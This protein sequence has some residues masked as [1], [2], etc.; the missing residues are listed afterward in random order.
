[1]SEKIPQNT[2]RADILDTGHWHLAVDISKDGLGAWLLPNA[3]LSINPRIII[4]KKWSPSEEGL[5]ERIEDA[6]YEN[7]AVLDDYSA[8]IIVESDRQLWLPASSYPTDDDCAEAY[9]KIYGGDNLDV[10]VN[11]LGDEK[12]AFMLVPGLKSFMQRSFPGAR[13]WSQQLLLR[14]AGQQPHDSYKYLVDIRPYSVDI[15][16]LDRNKLL[17]STTHIW[18]NHSDIA[19]IIFNILK[20]FKAQAS[21]TEIVF[22]GI[23]AVRQSIGKALVPYFKSVSQKNHELDG[24]EIPTGVYLAIN[25][26]KKYA[27]HT[28]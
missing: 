9:V 25:R 13:I 7:P 10:M 22:S 14:E 19:Y 4:N 20:T 18:K 17:C 8:D 6:V 23:H 5:L 2:P 27:H 11:D 3:T 24:L 26:K 1:M 28:R 12:C 16:L 21:D 15:V